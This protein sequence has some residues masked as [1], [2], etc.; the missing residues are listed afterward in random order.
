MSGNTARSFSDKWHKNPKGFFEET[1]REG[2]ETQTW[3]LGRNGFAS[4]AALR[5]YLMDKRR[6]LDAG[7]GNG[8]G[9]RAAAPAI[10]A[11]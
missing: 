8:Q 10:I 7:C 9:H 1:L 3:I 11:G 2:S 6:V 5:A 4:A